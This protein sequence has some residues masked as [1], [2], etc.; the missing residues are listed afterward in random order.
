MTSA[1]AGSLPGCSGCASCPSHPSPG[2]GGNG[3]SPPLL[4]RLPNELF[5]AGASYSWILRTLLNTDMEPLSCPWPTKSPQ[6]LLYLG[7]C[8]EDEK[9]LPVHLC[10]VTSHALRKKKKKKIVSVCSSL[11]TSMA[12]EAFPSLNKPQTFLWWLAIKAPP[13]CSWVCIFGFGLDSAFERCAVGSAD[14]HRQGAA[15]STGITYPGVPS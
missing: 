11:S 9:R 8:R 7:G 3:G 15:N 14:R 12:P 4:T 2:K 1:Q 10:P 5:C 13:S 6:L